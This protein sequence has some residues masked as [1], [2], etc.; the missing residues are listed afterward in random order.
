MTRRTPDDFT[1]DGGHEGPPK[2]FME[3]SE[4]AARVAEAAYNERRVNGA[5]DSG[6]A[7][8][9]LS[10]GMVEVTDEPDRPRP[11]PSPP[12]RAAWAL[13]FVERTAVQ[14]LFFG[15]GQ[16]MPGWLLCEVEFLMRF[17]PAVDRTSKEFRSVVGALYEVGFQIDGLVAMRAKAEEFSARCDGGDGQELSRIWAS[18]SSESEPPSVGGVIPLRDLA[19]KVR[20]PSAM[21]HRV[22]CFL[23]EFYLT[24]SWCLGLV[25]H[26]EQ[27]YRWDGDFYRI[28][29]DEVLR[30]DAQ[31][32]LR[33]GYQVAY[34]AKREE[35]VASEASVS[36]KARGELASLAELENEVKLDD[37]AVLPFWLPGGDWPQGEAK[38]VMVFRNGI[39]HLKIDYL[40]PVTPFLLAT[41]RIGAD[42]KPKAEC[43]RFLQFLDEIFAGDAGQ[44][45]LLQEVFGYILVGDTSRHKIFQIIGPRRSGKGTIGRLFAQTPRAGLRHAEAHQAG[46]K[47]RRGSADQPVT[48]HHHGR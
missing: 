16:E 7:Q 18:L 5:A 48:G 2:S 30:Q 1:I 35:W 36:G 6:I 25:R 37:R 20:L 23:K 34:D 13:N 14:Q 29:P 4:E 10:P 12:L 26:R 24:P 43:P 8:F 41:T 9:K 19:G 21:N 44:I 39:Y 11:D 27:L 42:W 15:S 47:L 31:A 40:E 22:L 3:Q 17:L 33:M 38:G 28:V 32:F 46:R 45:K